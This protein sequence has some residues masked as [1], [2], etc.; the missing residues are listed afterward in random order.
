MPTYHSERLISLE[1]TPPDVHVCT[2]LNPVKALYVTVES[3]KGHSTSSSK[4]KF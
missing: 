1:Y 2:Y 3:K 4:L